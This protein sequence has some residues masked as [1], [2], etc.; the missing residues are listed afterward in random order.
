MQSALYYTISSNTLK[1]QDEIKPED[2]FVMKRIRYMILRNLLLVPFMWI[3]L[4]YH[5]A[6]VD[7]YTEEQH[8]KMLRFIVKRA[9]KG[10]NV[11][12]EVHGRENIPEK[13]GFIFFPNHQGLYDVLAILEACPKP[14]SVVAKKEV[15]NQYF[16]KKVFACMKAHMIDRNDIRQG[17]EVITEVSKEV[18][19][20]RNY[21]IFAEGTRSKNGNEVQDFKGGSF[22][23]ATKA[24]CPI[25]PIALIDSFKPFDSNTTATPVTVQVHFL[26]PLYYEEYKD[27]KTTEIAAVVKERIQGV[28]RQYS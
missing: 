28:I 16:L 5:A 6:H 10:G 7:K 4:F 25:V 2:T 3:R 23:A 8:F 14:F 19:E 11:T 9:N 22:K 17:L 24:K 13:N 1:S 27:M 21:I 15:E 26:K 18:A 12:I 20:G